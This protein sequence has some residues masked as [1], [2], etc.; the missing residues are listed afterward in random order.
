M[1]I[2][3]NQARLLTLTARQ[4]DLELRAQRI[5]AHKMFLSMQSQAEALKYTNALA[6]LNG[7]SISRPVSSKVVTDKEA[8][9]ETKTV[10]FDKDFFSTLAGKLGKTIVFKK[11]DA[12]VSLD[13]ITESLLADGY[14][15]YTKVLKAQ[16]APQTAPQTTQ[17]VEGTDSRVGSAINQILAAR[18]TKP[19]GICW[20][21]IMDGENGE[22]PFQFIKNE[23]GNYELKFAASQVIYADGQRDEAL[24]ATYGDSYITFAE[25]AAA[26]PA[27]FGAFIYNGNNLVVTKEDILA[28]DPTLASVIDEVETA[29]QTAPATQPTP[30]AESEPEY[31][32]ELISSFAFYVDGQTV[33]YSAGQTSATVTIDHAAV[34]HIEYEYGEA[35]VTDVDFVAAKAEYEAAMSA[36]S[37]DEKLLDMELTQINTEHKAIKTEYD[38]VKSLVQDNTE[39]SFNV[40]G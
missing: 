22:F 38:A 34:T 28:F 6:S 2:S 29:A 19:S 32:Y 31:I 8:W 15:P 24:I 1:G 39:K 16:P 23:D 13:N 40:F 5:S 11:D 37:N 18:R 7:A 20:G 14:L 26:S 3:A 27:D 36:L 25:A 33:T 12:E 35:E 30:P 17:V 10:A 21:Q 9:T 4:H